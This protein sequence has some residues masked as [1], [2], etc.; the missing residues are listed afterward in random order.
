MLRK[1]ARKTP[2]R[3][4]GSFSRSEHQKRWSNKRKIVLEMKYRINASR[5]IRTTLK[6]I[7]NKFRNNHR[8]NQL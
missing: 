4:S 6:M 3:T 5:K 8:H 7:R 2:A 1:R